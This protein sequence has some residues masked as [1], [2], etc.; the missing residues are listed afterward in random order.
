[1]MKK[2]Y[3]LQMRAKDW[4]PWVVVREFGTLKAALDDYNGLSVKTGY[5]VVEAYTVVR[6]KAVK[7]ATQ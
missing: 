1:M 2:R 5:R 3:V 6:Y 4:S 7:V